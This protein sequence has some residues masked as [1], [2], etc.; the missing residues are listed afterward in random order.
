MAPSPATATTDAELITTGNFKAGE[1]D[2]VSYLFGRYC[3]FWPGSF[4][5]RQA[6][7][8]IGLRHLEGWNVGCLEFE[9]WCR[10]AREH[11]VRYVS[12][13]ISKYAVHPGQLSNTPVNFYEHID[14]RLK[15]IQDMFS[16][17]GFF[18]VEKA[19]EIER[20]APREYTPYPP[21]SQNSPPGS[22]HLQQFEFH[23]RA[24][25]LTEDVKVFAGGSQRSGS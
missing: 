9:I 23:A 2:F 8:D 21:G 14:N 20:N 7:L 1:F 18:G 10:L 17:D 13:P 19:R 25:N 3:P 11:K 5:R 16:A 6:L 15:L 22:N 4:F 24:H 12:T